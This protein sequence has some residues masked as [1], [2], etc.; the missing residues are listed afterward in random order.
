MDV[1]D[2]RRQ[3]RGVWSPSEALRSSWGWIP[4]PPACGRAPSSSRAGPGAGPPH[5]PRQAVRAHCELVLDAAGDAV[6]GGQAPGRRASS[7]SGA[8]GW[9]ALARAVRRRLTSAGLLVIADAKRG[10]I[11]VS[12]RRLRAGVLRRDRDPVRAGPRARRRRADRQ[13]AAR[14]RFGG[15]ARAGGP[16]PAPAALFVLVRTSNPG[17]ADVQELELAAGGTVSDG[18]AGL[19]AELGADGDRAQ[20]PVRRRRG[21][22]GDRAR[23]A[24]GAARGDAARRP[25]APGRRGAGRPGGGSGAGV[26][27]GPAPAGWWPRPGGSSTRTSA[28]VAS[29]DARRAD[30]AAARLPGAGLEHLGVSRART[31]RGRRAART[32]AARRGDDRAERAP[33]RLYDRRAMVAK[34][35]RLLAP[36]A[37]A[38]VAV[39]VY[40]IVH[41]GLAKQHATIVH[42]A[43]RSRPG[44]GA[45]RTR[46]A[47][48]FYVVRSGDTL[49]TISVKT[50]VSD[51]PAP[52]PQ[53]AGVAQQPAD[54][55]A[56]EAAAVSRARAASLR[57]VSRLIAIGRSCCRRRPGGSRPPPGWR[58]AGRSADPARAE[59]VRGDPGLAEGTGQELYGGAPNRPSWRSP[60]RP[61]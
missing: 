56:A 15:P 57:L 49:S 58:R 25:P 51:R 7:G 36:L 59:R 6:R 43:P 32:A 17:A 34:S 10:D 52:E 42:R 44:Q 26:R 2:V 45:R 14:S 48:K 60:A 12:A 38:A 47:P 18:L 3:A 30:E 21:H 50:H 35:A 4:T 39:G 20:R 24:R 55:S 19:V 9:A 40:M 53:P 13:P 46:P 22:R 5:A 33:W 31:V 16:R 61:S 23:A 8:P 1:R 11:D 29:R 37:L 28:R 54:R 41:A 27:A